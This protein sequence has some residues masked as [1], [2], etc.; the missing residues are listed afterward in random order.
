[1]H[2]MKK[3]FEWHPSENTKKGG[4]VA[5]KRKSRGFRKRKM[6]MM[7]G[8]ASMW[9]RARS[10][11]ITG[12]VAAAFCCF[13]SVA[14]A[15]GNDSGTDESK[16]QY[17]MCVELISGPGVGSEFEECSRLTLLGLAVD[18]EI[19]MGDVSG[20]GLINIGLGELRPV[21]VRK[22]TDI[23]SVDL[24][25]YAINGN[26]IGQVE[27]FAQEKRKG[28]RRL[29]TTLEVKLG[30]TFVKSIYFDEEQ[31]AESM[32]LMFTKIQVTVFDRDENG[33]ILGTQVF[34]WDTATNAPSCSL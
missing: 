7:K 13:A 12:V 8:E 29:L 17:V 14:G 15:Q 34:C 11:S 1:M 4:N 33:D 25:K 32:E 30:R 5:L 31:L 16:L 10:L 22:S 6:G 28:W 3:P 27:L 26:S 20:T 2:A 23:A 9:Q 24:F 18:R 21:V 19:E